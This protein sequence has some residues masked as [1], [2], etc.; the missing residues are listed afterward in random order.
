[1]ALDSDAV[2]HT[3]ERS[4]GGQSSGVRKYYS[5]T[6]RMMDG[7]YVYVCVCVRVLVCVCVSSPGIRALALF[8][9]AFSSFRAVL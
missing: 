7:V 5:R 1:M 4:T 3:L 2:R 6:C 9:S 8:L